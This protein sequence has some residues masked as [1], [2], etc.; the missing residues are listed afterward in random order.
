MVAL[1]CYNPASSGGGGGIYEWFN[2]L[3]GAY[4]AQIITVLELL[5][6][7]PR[8]DDD[9]EEVKDLRGACEGLTEIIVDFLV[10]EI[11]IHIRIIGFRGPGRGEFTLLTGFEKT[12]DN[13]I[14]GFY[15]AQ[16][17]QRMEG[18]LRDERR[19]PPCRII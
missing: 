18:V 7:E 2:G 1:R 3:S 8:W 6:A 9:V 4:R 11:E 17:N 13:A 10:G 12:N 5:R 14:Y 19:A 15:C 16:A